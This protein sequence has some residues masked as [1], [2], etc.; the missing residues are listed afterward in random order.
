MQLQPGTA[1]E[2][3]MSATRIRRVANLAEGWVAQ[4]MTPALVVL[5]ARRGVIVLHEAF[6]RL[7]PDT[8]APALPRD[9]IF[10]MA[11]ISKSITA[12]AAMILVEDGLL[13]LNRPVAEYIAEFGG[14][15]KEAVLVHHLL[16]HTSGLS[17]ED[18]AAHAEKKRGS[19]TIP[20]VPATQHPQ[21][22]DYLLHGY[23]TPLWK[24]P[25]VEM[26][27]CNTGY[28]L[29]G[30]II[31]RVSGQSLSAFCAERIFAPLGMNDSHYV[32]PDAA[33][34]RIVKRAPDN[35]SAGLDDP[36]FH[37]TPWA[38][39]GLLTTA[40]DLA[41]FGQ[42]LLN[43]G[44]YADARL[45]SPATVHTMTRNQIPGIS[46]YKDGEFFPEA[47]WGYGWDVCGD[48]KAMY[49]GALYSPAAFQH[50][51][52][53]GVNLWVDPTYELVG[54]YFS[55]VLGNTADGFHRVSPVDLFMNAVTASIIDE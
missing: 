39:A 48:K 15:G 27:Y 42:M 50:S 52:A 34:P 16:T 11:S 26:A 28:E 4:G 9:A 31:R 33:Q 7:T 21:I 23:D 3:G 13:G 14:A 10:P 54:V 24:P 46:A 38:C 40:L 41:I 35:P 45:L 1:A 30:E 29:L 5:V 32:L 25:G 55:V 36:A 12:T 53:G 47:A 49:D 20:P 8:A 18:V 22:H 2:V 6:G 51:G 44:V 17:D 43:R 37:A 19:V